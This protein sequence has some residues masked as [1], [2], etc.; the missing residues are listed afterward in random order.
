MASGLRSPHPDL[1][2][3]KTRSSPP[4]KRR[5]RRWRAKAQST[6]SRYAEEI[7]I[8]GRATWGLLLTH[9]K[10]V[11][12]DPNSENLEILFLTLKNMVGHD[13]RRIGSLT[14]RVRRR[15]QVQQLPACGHF[16]RSLCKK[17]TWRFRDPQWRGAGAIVCRWVVLWPNPN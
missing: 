2:S 16:R 6:P 15:L 14:Q 10:M 12:H 17:K 13:P 1:A 7:S 4:T 8:S 9:K 3:T 11:G 5:R